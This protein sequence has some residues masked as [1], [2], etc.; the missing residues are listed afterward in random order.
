[1][2]QHTQGRW[3]CV[4]ADGMAYLCAD[5]DDAE[6]SAKLSDMDWPRSSPHTA[7]Q[8]VDATELAA[9]EAQRDE[10]LEAL[11]DARRELAY[12]A[13]QKGHDAADAMIKKMEGA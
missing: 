5:K 8:L 1:M 2:T 3:Y 12:G 10:L 13:R 9:V 6:Q 7:V 4:S 11:K